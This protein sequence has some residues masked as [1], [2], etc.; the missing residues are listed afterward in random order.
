LTILPRAKFSVIYKGYHVASGVEGQ[1]F[2]VYFAKSSEPSRFTDNVAPSGD[3]IGLNDATNVPGATVFSG[4]AG[5]RAI[6]VNKNDGQKV[7]G[8]GFFQD[9]LIIFKEE[10]I[11]QLYFNESDGFVVERISSSYGAVCHGAIASVENDCYFLTDKGIYVLGNEPNYYA[12]IRTNELSS[13]I[14]PLLQRIT[15]WEKCRAIYHDDRYW[16]TVPLDDE[17][18]NALIVYDRRFYAWAYWDNIYA[19]DMIIFKDPSGD[20]RKHF[21][22]LD[23]REPSMQEFVWGVYN[24][25]GEAIEQVFR[26]RAFDAKRIETEKYWYTIRPIFRTATGEVVINYYTENGLDGRSFRLDTSVTG[27]IGLDQ[28]GAILLGTSMPDTYTESDLGIST[29]GDTS[30]TS[31]DVGHSVFD[32]G[33]NLDSRVLKVEF[34]NDKINESFALMG[35]VIFLQQKDF[36]RMDGDFTFR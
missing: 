5:P 7:T 26:T 12:S 18:V 28:I 27:G 19:T 2:R 32:I 23:D 11:Y 29:G 4:A 6:D 22:F 35:W 16:L 33:I 17:D 20:G 21:Y 25:N 13:R 10:S 15:E 30:S 14:K 34:S 8:I 3:D 1:P 24:D 9:V 31:T 36:Q